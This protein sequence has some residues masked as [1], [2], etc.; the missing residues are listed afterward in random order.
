MHGDQ[1]PRDDIFIAYSFL[2]LFLVYPHLSGLLYLFLYD[3][4]SRLIMY[5]IDISSIGKN[6]IVGYNREETTPLVVMR[7]GK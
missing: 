3:L 5:Y 4:L 1:G 2:S 6:Y 7:N